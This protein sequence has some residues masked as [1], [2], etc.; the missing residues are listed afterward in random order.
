MAA[1]PEVDVAGA[2]VAAIDVLGLAGAFAAALAR[3][4]LR[5][6]WRGPASPFRNIAVATTRESVRSLMGYMTSLPIDEFRALEQALDEVSRLVLPPFVKAQGVAM[7]SGEVGDVPGLWF[8][9]PGHEPTATIVYLHGGGYI[10]T[11]PSMYAVFMAHLA[12]ITGCE[13]F[14]ADYRLAPEFPYPAATEDVVAV[15]RGLTSAGIASERLIIAGDSGGG[16]LAGSVLHYC[17]LNGVEIPAA[18]VLFSPEVSLVLNEPS[19]RENAALDV[20]PWNIPTNPYLHG[21]DPQDPA[22]SILH[23]D[24]SKWPPTFLSYGG[25]E[26]MRDAL[27]TFATRLTEAGIPSETHEVPDMFHVFPFLL[28]WTEESQ[29]V[30]R[31]IH[32]FLESAVPGFES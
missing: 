3:T 28:P 20:L 6:P 15:L 7:T 24:L 29:T 22:V 23:Q 17:N 4:A 2:P 30:Y 1:R 12:R 14:V 5:L 8:R 26:V 16:G 31:Q 19:I 9:R 27:R 18:V 10:G 13:V 11:S 21:F 32:R 25:D